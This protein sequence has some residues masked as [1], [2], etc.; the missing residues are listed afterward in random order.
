M[1]LPGIPRDYGPECLNT[2]LRNDIET[3]IMGYIIGIMEKKW[4]LQGL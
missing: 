4:K 1:A 3:T 2:I